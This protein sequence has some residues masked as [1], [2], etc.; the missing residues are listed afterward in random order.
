MDD[1]LI[2]ALKRES[3][4]AAVE[5]AARTPIAFSTNEAMRAEDAPASA[6][7]PRSPS[8]P[9]APPASVLP[10]GLDPT[11]DFD[12]AAIDA[13]HLLALEQQLT[14]DPEG[15]LSSAQQFWD[16]KLTE[17]ELRSTLEKARVFVEQPAPAATFLESA[18]VFE[19][20]MGMPADWGFEGYDPVGLPI[21]PMNT[22]FE[23][24]A[25]GPM[26]ALSWVGAKVANAFK[27]KPPFPRHTADRSFC[28][29][30]G[31]IPT[32]SPTRIPA[33]SSRRCSTASEPPCT[34][35]ARSWTTFE[36]AERPEIGRL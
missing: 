19:S 23:T 33:R 16:T 10:F 7:P 32:A 29:G 21:S 8:D 11:G 3:P 35:G 13:S 4:P 25:D 1:K 15:V 24:V 34:H 36:R 20:A 26:Y 6:P 18:H 12:L 9:S 5:P 31:T 28:R 22:K 27:P 17:S 30:S 2:K 14:E